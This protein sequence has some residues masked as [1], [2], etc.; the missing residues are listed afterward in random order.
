[1]HGLDILLNEIIPA[2]G[3]ITVAR[4]MALCLEDPDWGYYATREPFGEKGDFITAPEISQIFGE[5]IGIWAAD[6]WLRAGYTWPLRLVELGPGRGSLMADALRA[7]SALK[8]FGDAADCHMV[9]SSARLRRQQQSLVQATWHETIDTLPEGAAIYIANEFFDA[10]PIHQF[11][12]SDVGWQE[13][14]IA[15]DQGELKWVEAD[16]TEAF[17]SLPKSRRQGAKHGDIL[18]WCPAGSEICRR[19]AGRIVSAG[20]ALLIIDYGYSDPAFGD[21]FQAV[22]RHRFTDPLAA[23]GQADLTAHVDFSM[24]RQG[25][26]GAGATARGPVPQGDF[27]NR[28]GIRVRAERLKARATGEQAANIDSAVDRLTSSQQMGQLFKAMA[29]TGQDSPAPAGF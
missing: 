12:R 6:Y 7:V 18:E 16:P 19:L 10:L 22:Q 2:E 8:E 11:V 26:E 13:R 28:L 20:G 21:S 25:A 27:L 15:A 9:E 1:M 17:Q 5:L 14:F 4:Y 3:P 29:V 23:P 24:L